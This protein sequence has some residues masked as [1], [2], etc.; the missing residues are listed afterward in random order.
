MFLLLC[1][2]LQLAA[3]AWEEIESNRYS[4]SSTAVPSRIHDDLYWEYC[5]I[6]RFQYHSHYY[7]TQASVC[8]ALSNIFQYLYM[9]FISDV[10]LECLVRSLLVGWNLWRQFSYWRMSFSFLTLLNKDQNMDRLSWQL[11]QRIKQF[12]SQEWTYEVIRVA[13]LVTHWTY[14]LVT[15][16]FTSFCSRHLQFLQIYNTCFQYRAGICTSF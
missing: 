15:I 14:L 12:L 5:A 4:P 10:E 1:H 9:S 11:A 7:S 3:I 8:S 2:H 6:Q 13:V 16:F